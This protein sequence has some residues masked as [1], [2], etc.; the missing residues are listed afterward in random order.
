VAG[1]VHL[2]REWIAAR[3]REQAVLRKRIQARAAAAPWRRCPPTN[4]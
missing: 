3:A 2:R 1:G 4:R